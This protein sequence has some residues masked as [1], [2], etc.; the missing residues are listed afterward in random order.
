MNEF[1]AIILG[2]LGV[3]IVAKKAHASF[4]A[5]STVSHEV[6]LLARTIWGEARGEDTAGMTAVA[7]VIMNRLNSGKFGRTIEEVITQPYQFSAWNINDPNRALMLAVDESDP[8]FALALSIARAAAADALP[9]V[10]NGADHYHTKDVSPYW[11][12]GHQAIAQ[13]GNHQFFKLV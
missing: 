10:T 13:I 12:V 7:N 8:Q 5:G 11:S 6:D 1:I 4:T 3:G 2:L 9:D